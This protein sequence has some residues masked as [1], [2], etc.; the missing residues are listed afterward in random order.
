MSDEQCL[1]TVYISPYHKWLINTPTPLY[2]YRRIQSVVLCVWSE[3][4]AEQK[5]RAQHSL[6]S[7]CDVD[8]SCSQFIQFVF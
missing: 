1:V 5:I 8:L 7:F 2:L 6:N 4:V 3:S